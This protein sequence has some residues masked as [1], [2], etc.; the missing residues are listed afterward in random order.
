MTEHQFDPDWPYGHVTLDGRKARIICKDRGSTA[1]AAPIV[2]LIGNDEQTFCYLMNGHRPSPA[3][4]W[5]RMAL[6]NAPAPEK[7]MTKCQLDPYWPHRHVT[8]DWKKARIV[9]ADMNGET[10]SLV[11]VV[12]NQYGTEECYSCTADGRFYSSGH[13][14][15]LDIFNAP[16]PKKKVWVEGW[17][18]V[19]P[20]GYCSFWYDRNAADNMEISERIACIRI[21]QEIEEGEGL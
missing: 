13:E 2:A 5:D 21:D 7:K 4:E 12:T 9:C 3:S 8:R 19:Y 15:S 1:N 20:D 14:S 6:V 18:N 10:D 11:V 17:L 16:E